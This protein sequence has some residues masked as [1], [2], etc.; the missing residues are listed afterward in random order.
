MT[1]ELAQQLYEIQQ[2][3]TLSLIA[4]AASTIILSIVIILK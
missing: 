4:T 2:A 3:A 1:T